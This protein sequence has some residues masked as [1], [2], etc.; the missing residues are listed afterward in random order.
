MITVSNGCFFS[1]LSVDIRH[2]RVF[3]FY[4]RAYSKTRKPRK[5]FIGSFF[6][7]LR[8]FICFEHFSRHFVRSEHNSW[9]ATQSYQWAFTIIALKR[10]FWLLKPESCLGKKL[11]VFSSF[12]VIATVGN[13]CFEFRKLWLPA[14]PVFVFCHRA[15]SK[16]RKPWKISIS[17]FFEVWRLFFWFETLF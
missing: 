17:L 14:F 3:V 13:G 12:L 8:L 4:H 16:T 1:K 9:S 10:L 11:M 7:V 2:F 15:Y 5:I 6:E